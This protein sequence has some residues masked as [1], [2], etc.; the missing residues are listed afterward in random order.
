MNLACPDEVRQQ[1]DGLYVWQVQRGPEEQHPCCS[2]GASRIAQN[3]QRKPPSATPRRL[4]Y[5]L[6]RDCTG[7][8]KITEITYRNERV[9]HL[10]TYLEKLVNPT[11]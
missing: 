9:F 10:K 1:L 5:E 3:P 2:G 4:E 7:Q 11:P 6:K 8:W